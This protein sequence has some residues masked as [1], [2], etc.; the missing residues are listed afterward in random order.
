VTSNS[1]NLLQLACATSDKIFKFVKAIS[2][3]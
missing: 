3:W 2:I 1:F